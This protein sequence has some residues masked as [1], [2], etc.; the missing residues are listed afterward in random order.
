MSRFRLLDN[1]SDGF[2]N[3][4]DLK[5]IYESFNYVI[6]DE[7]AERIL[8]GIGSKSNG[9]SIEDFASYLEVINQDKSR[10]H[11]I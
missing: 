10:K 7:H 3:K 4:N 1:D 6:S 9:I 2:V 8:K 5:K 11:Q